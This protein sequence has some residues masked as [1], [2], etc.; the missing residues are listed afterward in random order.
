MCRVTRKTV[1][2]S[3][4]LRQLL[5]AAWRVV[6]S[7]E[8]DAFVAPSDSIQTDHGYANLVGGER[9]RLSFA[10]LP[11]GG[12]QQWDFELTRA[13]LEPAATGRWS[14]IEV[15]ATDLEE[16]R[17]PVSARRRRSGAAPPGEPPEDPHARRL[18]ELLV[19][20]GS[21]ELENTQP[22]PGLVA[23]ASSILDTTRS[24][25]AQAAKLEELFMNDDAVAEVFIDQDE[26]GELLK[27]W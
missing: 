23:A 17:A 11:E 10:F 7:E 9:D 25:A 18:L 19:E 26:L 27:R 14:T 5:Q 2:I 1:D 15:D 8:D 22:P 16:V 13:Q 12:D 20:H 24:V 4:D 3:A 6:E 21:I